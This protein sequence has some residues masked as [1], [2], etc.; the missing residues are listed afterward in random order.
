MVKWT[1]NDH[2]VD[3]HMEESRG[4]SRRV[5]RAGDEAVRGPLSEGEGS[6]AGE[7]AGRRRR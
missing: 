6:V 7:M 4:R 3:R 2:Q 1:K 5:W